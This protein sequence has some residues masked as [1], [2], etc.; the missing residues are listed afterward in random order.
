M[1]LFINLR[2]HIMTVCHVYTDITNVCE[3]THTITVWK[4]Q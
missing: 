3:M 2:S 1:V 4:S